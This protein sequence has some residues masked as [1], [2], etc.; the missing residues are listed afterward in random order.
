MSQTHAKMEELI[1]NL[2]FHG[3]M[4]YLDFSIMFLTL[5]CIMYSVILMPPSELGIFHCRSQRSESYP[6]M[7]GLPGCAGTSINKI[8]VN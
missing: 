7:V 1:V 3:A 5:Y 4:Q 2:E 8:F 6:S